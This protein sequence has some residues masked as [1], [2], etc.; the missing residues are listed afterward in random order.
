MEHVSHWRESA[1][2]AAAV[3]EQVEREVEVERVV[4]VERE[5]GVSHDEVT[6]LGRLEPSKYIKF[7]HDS[8][9]FVT[10]H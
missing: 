7:R 6:S 9:K 3:D 10:M 2:I 4:E 8:F 1:C 5:V